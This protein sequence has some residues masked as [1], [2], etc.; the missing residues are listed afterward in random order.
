MFHCRIADGVHEN[1]ITSFHCEVLDLTIS[2]PQLPSP[3]ATQPPDND[4]RVWI[5]VNHLVVMEIDAVISIVVDGPDPMVM[6]TGEL[7]IHILD[8]GVDLRN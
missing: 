8:E 5:D 1:G 3:L 7:G 4:P 2:V 6:G